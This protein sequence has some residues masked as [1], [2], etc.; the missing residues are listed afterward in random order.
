MKDVAEHLKR[1]IDIENV[2]KENYE[3][4]FGYRARHNLI[5]EIAIIM[6]I[7]LLGIIAYGLLK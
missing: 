7:I 3:K 2:R 5:M 6:E 1:L 4:E